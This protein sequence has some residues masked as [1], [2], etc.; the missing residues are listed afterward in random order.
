[1]RHMLRAVAALLLLAPCIGQAARVIAIPCDDFD[2]NYVD[3]SWAGRTCITDVLGLLADGHRFNVSFDLAYDAGG[4]DTS[5]GV[6]AA[7]ARAQALTNAIAAIDDPMFIGG[8][9][10]PDPLVKLLYGPCYEPD[11]PGASSCPYFEIPT[12][13]HD[14]WFLIDGR[15]EGG[16][17]IDGN[18]STG[19]ALFT[20]VPEP[21][22]LALLGLGLAG[23]GLSRRRKAA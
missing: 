18:A 19:A 6:D 3:P 2:P 14:P 1:M 17:W 12:M 8:D 15:L 21:G 13:R 5:V 22:S 11:E 7:R 23:L 4:S 9:L 20:S 10:T 16:W